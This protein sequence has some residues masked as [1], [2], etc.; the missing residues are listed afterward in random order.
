MVQWTARVIVAVLGLVMVVAVWPVQSAYSQSDDDEA[1]MG[2]DQY[3]EL[4]VRSA[5]RKLGR[6]LDRGEYGFQSVDLDDPFVVT[7]EALGTEAPV[8]FDILLEKMGEVAV[9]IDRQRGWEQTYVVAE[10]DIGPIVISQTWKPR[11]ER[12]SD[13]GCQPVKSAVEWPPHPAS[14]VDVEPF[15]YWGLRAAWR[16]PS[17]GMIEPFDEGLEEAL[18]K[19]IVEFTKGD[20]DGGVVDASGSGS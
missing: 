1:A 3:M 2:C 7:G 20:G 16:I 9:V 4:H 17:S 12:G 8:E 6:A 10:A 15:R 13:A 14:S 5:A 18:K 19:T 11:D